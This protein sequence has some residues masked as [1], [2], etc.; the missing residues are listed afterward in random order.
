MNRKL[1]LLIAPLALVGC[2]TVGPT[3]SEISTDHYYN[4]TIPDRRV[5]VI[6]KIDERGSFGQYPIKI[7]PGPHRVVMESPRHG[8]IRDAKEQVLDMT[9][10]PCKRYYLNTQFEN[11]TTPA[12]KPVVDYVEP[13]A[14]CRV[15]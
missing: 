9:F 2:Q 11:P 12:W 8:H 14:G 1:M 5:G 15:G 3:W 4:T 7:D 13:I 10:E 6:V